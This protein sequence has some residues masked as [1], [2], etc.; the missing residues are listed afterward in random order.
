ME[1]TCM[2]SMFHVMSRMDYHVVKRVFLAEESIHSGY[3]VPVEYCACFFEIIFQIFVSVFLDEE[4]E[5]DT[6]CVEFYLLFPYPTSML[7]LLIKWK[8]S[9]GILPLLGNR[10][11]IYWNVKVVYH[12]KKHLSRLYE[13]MKPPSFLCRAK[14]GGFENLNVSFR[15]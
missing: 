14:E 15:I 5:E 3:V 1:E 12:G 11:I 4:E 10:R 7:S 13:T 9:K 6:L 2:S 8:V